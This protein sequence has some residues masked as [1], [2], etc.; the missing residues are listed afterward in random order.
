MQFDTTY[1]DDFDENE[2]Y[3]KVLF[4]SGYNIQARELNVL[5]SMTQYQIGALGNHL[6]KNGAKISGCSSSFVQY[7]YVRINDISNK[8]ELFNT[9]Y[10]IVGNITK[11][12]ATIVHSYNK[13]DDEDA[14][15]LVMYTTTGINQ[16]SAFLPGETLNIFDNDKL[17]YSINVLSSDDP[18]TDT[19]IS[20]IGKS[21][22]F[23]IDEGV[24]FYNKY[25]LKVQKQTILID[26]YLIKNNGRIVSNDAYRVG[27]DIVEDIVT[28]DNDKSL[29]D[30]H[31]GYS[32]FGA[33][34]ADRY[35]INLYLSIR[36]YVDNGS[37]TNFIMLAKVRQNHV[38]E[39]KKD[40]TEYAEIMKEFARRMHETYGDFT[41][42]PWKSHFLNE[43]KSSLKDNQGWS[44][45]GDI[46]KYVAIVSPGAG[47]VKGYRV[48]TLTDTVVK[49]RKATDVDTN[50]NLTININEPNSVIVN[51]TTV[52]DWGF[53]VN[54][55]TESHKFL[56]YDVQNNLIGSFNVYDIYNIGSNKYKIFL[57]NVKQENN[58]KIENTVKVKSSV[59]S[60]IGTCAVNTFKNI[61][62]PTSSLL[63]P[64][65]IS[66]VN[67][68]TNVK[69]TLRCKL[70]A[71][72]DEA[73][74]YTFN[75]GATDTYIN[76]Q[77]A[78][79]WC[80]LNGVKSNIDKST[81]TITDKTVTINMSVSFANANITL[82]TSIIKTNVSHR[83]KTKSIKTFSINGN[84]DNNKIGSILDINSTDVIKVESITISKG[85]GTP[86]IDITSEYQL[87][88]SSSN[89]VY[90]TYKIRRNV[91]RN[92]NTDDVIN[93]TY[94]CFD[95]SIE[96]EYFNINSYSIADRAFIPLHNGKN[97]SDYFDFR[98]NVTDKMST[99][100]GA[101]PACNTTIFFDAQ[102]YM[103]RA[104]LLLIN[105]DNELYIKEGVP[106]RVAKLPNPDEDSMALYGIYLTPFSNDIQ[107]S[108]YDN[109][110]Y[111]TK[112]ITQL[113]N[114]VDNA[115]DAV[116]LT[117]LEMQTVNM[118]I[119]DSNGFD[120]YKNGFL[121]DNFKTFNM[122]DIAN[123]EYNASIDTK[124]G[125]LRPQFKQNNI[126]LVIDKSKSSNI[127]LIGNMAI[128][129]YQ[130]DLFIQNVYATQS[131][132]INPYMI[133]CNTGKLVL[134]PNI[135]TWADDQHL[136]NI[137]S[138]IDAGTNTLRELAD[139][140]KLL[141]TKYGAWT[142]F[143]QSIVQSSNTVIT[144]DTSS[145][146]ASIVN[147]S[148][149][150]TT[151]NTTTT[152][153][154]TRDVTS[155]YVGSQS[156][157]YTI[158]NMIKDV[159]IIPY[160][161]PAVIQFY[162]SNLKPNTKVYAYF[163]GV[164]VNLKC[165]MITQIDNTSGDVLV[166]RNASMFGTSDLIS[167][168]D[169]NIIGEFRIP[170]N[171]FFTGEKRFVLTN[172]PLNSGN[173]DVETTRCESVYFAGGISQTKQNATLNVITPT[174]GDMTGKETSSTST[175]TTSVSRDVSV[176][177]I[178][179]PP[180]VPPVVIGMPVINQFEV[181]QVYSN[182][183]HQINWTVTGADVIDIA[184][185]N[186]HVV[187]NERAFQIDRRQFTGA[188]TARYVPGKYTLTATNSVG[189][190]IYS[191]TLLRNAKIVGTLA[192]SIT[193]PALPL[194]LPPRF[195]FSSDPVA[196]G[197]K[198]PESCFISKV[199]VFF[200]T[201]DDKAD[202][203]WF[204]IREMINGYPSRDAIA[205]KEIS[206]ANLKKYESK[207]A[208][209]SYSVIFDVP[210]YI[211]SSRA[212]A[213]VVGGFSPDT[214]LFISK[215][216]NKLLSSDKLLEEPPLNY[217]MFRSL[218]GDTWNAEQFDTMKI[219]IYRAV[220]D[221]TPSVISLHNDQNA[222][223][224]IVCPVDPIEI[225][226]GSNSV[227]IYARD[228]NLRVNDRVVINFSYDLYYTVDV[229]NNGIP[230]IGQPISTVTGSG[231]VKDIRSTPSLNVY[232]ISIDKMIGVFKKDQ[233]FICE[234]RKYEY[235]DLF[236][237]SD[238]GAAGI[239][240]IQ[241]IVIGKIKSLDTSLPESVAGVAIELFAKEHIVRGVDTI[242]SFIIEVESPF[243]V[244]GKFGGDNVYVYGNNI[245]YDT[246]NVSGQ[247]MGY[248]SKEKWEIALH[249][250]DDKNIDS[251]TFM[252]MNDIELSA[253]C[254][255]FSN[256]NEYRVMG[257]NIPSLSVTTTLNSVS[258]YISPVFNL[259]SF[260][261]TT[262]SNRI[263]NVSELSYNVAPNAKDRY[264]SET[265]PI[266]GKQ[267][268]KHITNKVILE[269]GARDMKIMFDIHS[270]NQ[271]D[272]DVY[273]KVFRP[274]NNTTDD[275]IG[276]IKLDNFTKKNTSNIKS[277]Y[278]SYD[279]SLTKNCTIWK[280]T[281]EYIAYRVK[282]VGKS[283]NSCRPVLFKNLRAIAIT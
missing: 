90:P 24:F 279:L 261:I 253:P 241:N 184:V 169:G 2:N 160:I 161:R 269:N 57:Y 163:D 32:N 221:M 155:T 79:A 277:D 40:D 12:E 76:D 243:T 61:I 48:S 42:S 194:P 280:D 172:D 19:S 65:G 36:D 1:I 215:L 97:I 228:H 138:T 116:S 174:F 73:G 93:V 268:Y 275:K 109:R 264:I 51:S 50:T 37:S 63:I 191:F 9:A 198:V 182:N 128:K 272:F 134:S 52:V 127:K 117:M 146:A 115:E 226:N 219:N 45:D 21:L 28:A 130:D 43:N 238:N 256:R 276:W 137:T 26:R 140:S 85:V 213:F 266:S 95:H 13:T 197:F 231:Y 20:P 59:G 72:L 3:Y 165:R 143:N 244:D 176:E 139:A 44:I 278:I 233:E 108:F 188:L 136:P 33:P 125:I 180:P 135:D 62:D 80:D 153:D 66:N 189:R 267:S 175:T 245:K 29:L 121:V 203:I 17:V 119:K 211:D 98:P 84:I 236:L 34:G 103:S 210:V 193:A 202:V 83:T 171:T 260:S 55:S 149:T 122:S 120:R 101:I 263:E 230:Q 49:G 249:T 166:N 56:M 282:L 186:G 111:T 5:Q 220:F 208:S 170:A 192:G 205:H 181:A 91:F 100:F 273:V 207:D 214:R 141:G 212:Y 118:S 77:Y 227:R 283:P 71:Q 150:T 133:F 248:N 274:D 131:V 27:L 251:V 102:Y 258:P 16:E 237:L 114:R 250:M 87:E 257:K 159:S 64:T 39:Y 132:S 25:F 104:D 190:V 123:K 173:K 30:P 177:T 124:N 204:E 35:K 218:N 54:E 99:Y 162:A 265:T 10:K 252:P 38:V 178:I 74:K 199:D 168:A 106:G 96:G 229:T 75:A 262:I 164:D 126:K 89:N 223:Y 281:N 11:I 235:R 270:P 183:S 240:I 242:D 216:G 47:Y 259:D 239:P 179:I 82:I 255:I 6:F 225:Q 67:A 53:T 195:S 222:S 8:I 107:T 22:V 15:I 271:T 86:E 254:V 41:L 78:I 145:T 158:D 246:F 18:I 206:G 234:T 110:S 147:T 142:D 68:I 88:A 217:T 224:D 209:I 185:P 4:K 112:E 247:Y 58:F 144:S 92:I 154:A 113:K 200:E 232:Q 148:T 94:S 201:V 151:T 60:F 105:T 157:S 129:D 187:P 152:T 23:T 46:N 156:Q 7:D 69:M 14:L 81:I 31:Y 196:Q 70:V 167:D